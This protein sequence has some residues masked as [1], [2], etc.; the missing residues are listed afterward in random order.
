MKIKLRIMYNR[1]NEMEL[2]GNQRTKTEAFRSLMNLP[3]RRGVFVCGREREEDGREKLTERETKLATSGLLGIGSAL[4]TGGRGADIDD[5]G[6]P[7]IPF[8]GAAEPSYFVI[9][10]PFK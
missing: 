4:L 8:R 5:L 6:S 3:V 2:K 9:G 1:E 7:T 10:N